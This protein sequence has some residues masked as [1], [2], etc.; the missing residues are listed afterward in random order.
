MTRHEPPAEERADCWDC[1]LSFPVSRLHYTPGESNR[2]RG[3]CGACLPMRG[4]YY[5]KIVSNDPDARLEC[6]D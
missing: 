3:R 4:H 6:T 5:K 2:N 1:G